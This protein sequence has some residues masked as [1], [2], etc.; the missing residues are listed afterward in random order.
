MYRV[1]KDMPNLSATH[2]FKD[3]VPMVCNYLTQRK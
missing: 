1:I 2:I 3:E